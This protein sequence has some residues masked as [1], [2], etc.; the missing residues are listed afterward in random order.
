MTWLLVATVIVASAGAVGVALA[1]LAR[2]LPRVLDVL[3]GFGRELRPALVRVRNATDELRT[4]P[5]RR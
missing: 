3:D 5:P 2:T 1:R 4:A